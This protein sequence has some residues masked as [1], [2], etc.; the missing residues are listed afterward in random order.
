ML[1]INSMLS[2][3]L[4][5]VAISALVAS[6]PGPSNFLAAKNGARSGL[7]AA[8]VAI[9]GHMSAVLMLAILSAIGVGAMILAAEWLFNT[10]KMLG[11]GYLIYLGFKMFR[12]QVGSMP[13]LALENPKK[14]SLK[15]LWLEHFFVAI[16]NPKALL[17]FTAL[18]PQFIDINQGL[19]AQFLPFLMISMCSS[20]LFPFSYALFAYRLSKIKKIK[21][22]KRWASKGTGIAFLGF[23][24]ALA[25]TK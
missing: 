12:S 7:I 6:S 10:I 8:T 14:A 4:S 15:K 23:G 22:V 25:L 24:I 17:F 5:Y 21:K 19:T 16:G 18:F 11:A 20:F 2:V 3:Y 13:E 1:F 9:T